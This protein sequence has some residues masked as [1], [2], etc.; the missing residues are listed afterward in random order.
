MVKKDNVLRSHIT[1][2]YS[3]DKCAP[4]YLLGWGVTE[5]RVCHEIYK[6]VEKLACKRDVNDQ[7]EQ[8]PFS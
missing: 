2:A 6:V 8:K 3:R 7:N 1:Q 5:S 4:L